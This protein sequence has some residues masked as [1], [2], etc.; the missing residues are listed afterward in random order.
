MKVHIILKKEVRHDIER[1]TEIFRKLSQM[2]F[3]NH[4]I[5]RFERHGILTG[6]MRESDMSVASEIEGVES[7]NPDG[8]QD[9]IEE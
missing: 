7:V 6:F 9:A 1:K 8:T 2:G 5:E 3:A 4:N